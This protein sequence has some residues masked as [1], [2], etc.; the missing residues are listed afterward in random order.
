MTGSPESMLIKE[1][2]RNYE[3]INL[4]LIFFSMCM[5][6]FATLVSY[7]SYGLDYYIKNEFFIA[8]VI[9]LLYAFHDHA[10]F[11]SINSR[12]IWVILLFFAAV[13]DLI[14][15]RNRILN[16]LSMFLL[17]NIIYSLTEKT[18]K[19]MLFSIVLAEIVFTVQYRITSYFNSY[20]LA[21]AIMGLIIMLLIYVYNTDLFWRNITVYGLIFIILFVMASRTSLVAFAVSG[22]IILISSIKGKQTNKEISIVLCFFIFVVIVLLFSDKIHGLLFDK[23]GN[24]GYQ[25][26]DLSAGRFR[27]WQSI[28]TKDI[29]LFG[30]SIDFIM[31]TYNHEDAHNIFIQVV[32]KYGILTFI[33]FIL[34]FIDII[35]RIMKV[36]YKY[37][38]VFSSI[39]SFYFIAGMTENVLFLDCKSFI[40]TYCFCVSLAWLYK[41]SDIETPSGN[42]ISMCKHSKYI[43]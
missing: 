29:T 16:L 31:K 38:I 11:Q 23:W 22:M 15:G 8:L 13:S 36:S 42:A 37:R 32:C 4:I 41:I 18:I 40:I 21:T 28:I 39:F 26:N 35:R 9:I 5:I 14:N 30:H 6:V 2:K 7:G 43:K 10:I 24:L 1:N 27:M 34:W 3:L 33:V 17:F 19:S 20:A 12:Q 25:S